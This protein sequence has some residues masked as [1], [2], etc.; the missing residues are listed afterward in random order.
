MAGTAERTLALKLISDVGGISKGL[1]QVDRRLGKTAKAAASWGKAFAGALVIG[2]LERIATASIDGVKAF[3]EEQQAVRNFQKTV[4]A[5]GAPIGK[6]NKA[7]DLMADRAVNLGFDDGDL[8]M[9]MDMF[10]RKTGDIEKATRL[11]ALAMDIARAKN[12]S[13]ADAQRQVDQIYNGSARVLKAYGIE[14]RK[15]MEAV[16]AARRVERGKAAAWARKHPMEVLLGKVSDNFADV[17]GNLA[18]GDFDEAMKAGQKLARNLTRGIFGWTDKEGKRH[19]GLFDRLFDSTKGKDGKAKGII[20]RLGDDIADAITNTD[21]NQVFTDVLTGVK[22]FIDSGA[23]GTLAQVA[24]A[25]ALGLFAVDAAVTALTTL[26]SVPKLM[27]KGVVGAIT[28]VGVSIAGTMFGAEKVTTAAGSA[29]AGTITKAAE[30]KAVGAA[31]AGAGLSIGGIIAAGIGSLIAGAIVAGL[32]LATQ[33]ANRVPIALLSS[34]KQARARGAKDRG[35]VAAQ[36]RRIFPQASNAQIQRALDEAGFTHASSEQSQRRYGTNTSQKG[37]K[38][39][40]ASGGIV[41]ATPGGRFVRVAEGGEDEAIVPRH[42]WPAMGRGGSGTTVNIVVNAGMG[43]NGKQVG[44]QIIDALVPALRRGGSIRL[45]T[46][47]GS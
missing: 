42:L 16:E 23:A 1:G 40:F 26:F 46:A 12:I 39:G 45:K 14:G 2:G 37:G 18:S 24:G 6:A 30:G 5:M 3:R 41:P 21:W 4:K 10:V 33:E 34:A 29:I 36:L 25:L 19:A 17:V 8:I 35:T 22:G 11:N 13:L 38:T 44:E 47:L 7:L 28:T 15:G 9:G 31:A 20:T 43:T 27:V 32:T